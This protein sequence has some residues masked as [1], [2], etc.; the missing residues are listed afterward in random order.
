MLP[1]G[2]NEKEIIRGLTM[3]A[4]D[5]VIDLSVLGATKIVVEEYV[6][7]D[8]GLPVEVKFHM[9]NGQVASINIVANRGTNCACKSLLASDSAVLELFVSDQYFLIFLCAN[10]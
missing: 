5:I 6:G 2:F 10:S 4:N 1:N 7:S 8:D 3:S 9:F